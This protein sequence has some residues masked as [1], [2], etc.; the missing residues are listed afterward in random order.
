MSD[1]S[2]VQ[3]EILLGVAAL[4]QERFRKDLFW[5]SVGLLGDDLNIQWRSH[6]NEHSR[7]NSFCQPSSKRTA[8][9]AHR[10]H[11][12][13]KSAV[14][15]PPPPPCFTEFIEEPCEFRQNLFDLEKK[16]MHAGV[17][18]QGNLSMILWE[19]TGQAPYISLEDV[20]VPWFRTKA[21]VLT[22]LGLDPKHDAYTAAAQKC[23]PSKPTPATAA[24]VPLLRASSSQV[25]YAGAI[26]VCA[27]R[28]SDIWY[29]LSRVR[30]TATTL[31]ETRHLKT[32]SFNRARNV[33][34]RLLNLLFETF[35]VV[36]GGALKNYF[37]NSCEGCDIEKSRHTTHWRECRLIGKPLKALHG[38]SPFVNTDDNVALQKSL[39]DFGNILNFDKTNETVAIEGANPK[40]DLPSSN[41]N[42]SIAEVVA[43]VKLLWDIDII[44]DESA[45]EKYLIWPTKPGLVTLVCLM[46]VYEKLNGDEKNTNGTLRI[47]LFR[48]TTLTEVHFVYSCLPDV[49]KARDLAVKVMSKGG[50]NTV[51]TIHRSLRGEIHDYQVTDSALHEF[52]R[53]VLGPGKNPIMYP[54]FKID[55]SNSE[56]HLVWQIPTK[57]VDKLQSK[58]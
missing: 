23:M 16:T 27:A 25:G 13:I 20:R 28:R 12:K 41:Q 10:S 38:L 32:L 39:L 34:T 33:S 37:H 58:G 17:Q 18:S 53:S 15:P 14:T 5:V 8:S 36:D 31:L 21:D 4:L 57:D 6:V 7:Y 44:V 56:L 40:G 11:C 46:D 43:F 29:H 3:Q 51:G 42:V 9:A 24:L 54:I 52:A 49:D 30:A 35:E 47:A 2:Q 48:S 45:K 22:E 19:K 50:R 26:V 55:G 1:F